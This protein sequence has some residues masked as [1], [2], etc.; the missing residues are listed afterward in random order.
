MNY[1]YF[2]TDQFHQAFWVLK[3]TVSLRDS[4]FEYPQIS[5]DKEI[6]K[7]KFNYTLS[8]GGFSEGLSYL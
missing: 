2:L 5:F 8:A 6:T 4:S 1:D 3:R 7:F